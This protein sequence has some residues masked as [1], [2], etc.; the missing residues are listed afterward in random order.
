MFPEHCVYLRIICTLLEMEIETSLNN[1]AEIST[2]KNGLCPK[3]VLK[4]FHSMNITSSVYSLRVLYQLKLDCETECN[5]A[6]F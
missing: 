1:V 2:S 4:S 3:S 5:V 6:G